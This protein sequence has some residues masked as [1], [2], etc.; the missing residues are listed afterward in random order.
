M[1]R[2]VEVS[3]V[4]WQGQVGRPES[5]VCLPPLDEHGWTDGCPVTRTTQE[6]P[7]GTTFPTFLWVGHVTHSARG[8]ERK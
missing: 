3:C 4:C 6:G 5:Q 1:G 7:A 8:L 2:A